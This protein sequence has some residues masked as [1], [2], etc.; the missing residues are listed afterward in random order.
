MD[1]ETFN[2]WL[3]FWGGC[4]VTIGEGRKIWEITGGFWAH[5]GRV[6]VRAIL[7]GR[8]WVVPVER[9]RLNATCDGGR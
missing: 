4:R 5:G 8:Y 1:K 7:T 6:R 2:N 9:I 3:K